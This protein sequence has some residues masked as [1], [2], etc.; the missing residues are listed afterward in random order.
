MRNVGYIDQT[1]CAKGKKLVEF[2]CWALTE[3]SPYA[4]QL[5]YVPLPENVRQ[6]VFARLDQVTCNGAPL[7]YG[8]PRLRGA[9]TGFGPVR[10]PPERCGGGMM[11]SQ[12]RRRRTPSLGFL[13]RA[14]GHG[15]HPFRGLMVLACLAV[16]GLVGMIGLPLWRNSALSREAF[17]WRFLLSSRWDPALDRVFGALPFLQVCLR[18]I[19]VRR[20]AYEGL[21]NSTR[22]H[23]SR[24]AAERDGAPRCRVANAAPGK[25]H[26]AV[27]MDANRTLTPVL[28]EAATGPGTRLREGEVKVAIRHLNVSYRG[29]QAL[30]DVSLEVPTNSITAIIGPSGCGKSTLLR[31]INRMIDLVPGARAE[32]E[33]LLDGRTCSIPGSMWS[34]CAG[35]WACVSAPEPVSEIDLGQRRLWT[36]A[37]RH[38]GGA[39]AGGNRRTQPAR[40]RAVGGSQGQKSALALSGGQ[41]QRLCLARLWPSN[42]K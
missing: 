6:Q 9:W 17:G 4:E 38:R 37:V 23:P 42:A 21:G 41:Q 27:R 22:A 13:G 3:G 14:L 39:G 40:C 33:V 15:D 35:V 32:G 19:A 36:P 31:T 1:D 20:M 29:F 7:K 18:D 16:V 5:E 8:I 28:A 24:V 26:T 12:I 25:D 30:T 34:N 2:I 11:E 10:A